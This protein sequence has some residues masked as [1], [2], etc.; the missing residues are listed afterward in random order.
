MNASVRESGD[1]YRRT[2]VEQEKESW[3]SGGSLA[4]SL[5][6][7]ACL[8]SGG[9]DPRCPVFSHTLAPLVLLVFDVSVS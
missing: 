9:L 7:Q 5:F 8:S 3:S 1:F 4:V 2:A 6:P